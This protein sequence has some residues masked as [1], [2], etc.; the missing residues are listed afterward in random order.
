M[1]YSARLLPRF[2]I[3]A[4]NAFPLA[5]NSVGTNGIYRASRSDCTY[6]KMMLFSLRD[7]LQKEKDFAYLQ[8]MYSFF[9]TSSHSQAVSSGPNNCHFF[10]DAFSKGKGYSKTGVPNRVAASSEAYYL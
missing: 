7:F 4:L 6:N 10:R 1:L 8:K 5:E 9:T 2:L 3:L